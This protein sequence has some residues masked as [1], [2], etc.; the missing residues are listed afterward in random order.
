MKCPYCGFE[1]TQVKDSRPNEEGD[2][3]RRRRFCPSCDSRFTTYEKVQLKELYVIK[4]NGE[5]RPFDVDKIY[6]SIKTALRKRSVAEE[7]LD[8]IINNIVRKLESIQDNEIHTS[9]IG[10]AIME[11]LLKLDQ[12]AYVRFASVYKDFGNVEDFIKFIKK[13]ESNNSN[14]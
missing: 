6:R 2:V 7:K 4:K 11:E 10:E 5:K 13:L 8:L 1:D 12:V 9:N 3:I 14:G